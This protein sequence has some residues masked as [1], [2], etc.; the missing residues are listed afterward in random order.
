M[1]APSKISVVRQR[2]ADLEEAIIKAEAYITDGSHADW[3]AFRPLFTDKIIDGES[4]P[5]HKDWV[6]S[7]FIPRCE[8]A[9][10][11]AEK[12]LTRLEQ[13]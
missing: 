11:K 2:I 7:T 5:P 10:K 1:T 6:K 8:A 12:A 13:S 3:R 4:A 9:L